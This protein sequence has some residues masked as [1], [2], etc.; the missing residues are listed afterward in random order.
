MFLGA[1]PN[2]GSPYT[3]MLDET[4]L[5]GRVLNA[6]DVSQHYQYQE[7]WFDIAVRRDL[8]IDAENPTIQLDRCV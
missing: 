6:A 1:M 2:T 5:Y 4:L 3:G 8:T 7:S